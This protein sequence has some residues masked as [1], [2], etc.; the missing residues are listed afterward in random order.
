MKDFEKLLKKLPKNLRLK[1][2]DVIDKLASNEL[3]NLDINPLSD[4]YQVYR[5]RVGKIR[6]IFRKMG[7]RN[8]IMDMGFRGD[9][10]KKW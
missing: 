2:I 10:Y 1:L 9:I 8:F 6:V 7:D 3:E 5:C 4:H